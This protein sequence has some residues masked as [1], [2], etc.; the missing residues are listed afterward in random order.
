MGKNKNKKNKP[1]HKPDKK[2]KIE[3]L[4]IMQVSLRFSNPDADR[5]ADINYAFDQ[6]PDFICFGEA[7]EADTT[8]MIRNISNERGYGACT[9]PQGDSQLSVRLKGAPDARIK[10]K[11]GVMA[12]RAI[13]GSFGARYVRWARVNWFDQDIW[14]H[15][16]HWVFIPHVLESHGEL[17][18]VHQDQTTTMCNQVKKHGQGN[19]ISFF[20]GDINVDE[21]ADNASDH[22]NM[23][24]FIFRQK[25]LLTIWDELHVNPPIT[26]AHSTFDIIGSYRPD[27]QV[28]GK[29]YIV[30][31]KQNSDHRFVSAFY[32]I[33]VAKKVTTGGGGGDGGDADEPDD[34][35]GSADVDLFV[36]ANAGNIDWSDYLDNE[37]YPLPT[38]T[39]DSQYGG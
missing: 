19:A 8:A 14:M 12:H 17:T 32:D 37:L 38:A 4:H 1:K 29:R 31:P 20:A 3:Q 22:P 24:N 9:F 7:G 25:G 26:I 23:P 13:P 34:T 5:R 39:G 10:S 27:K 2:K 15:A 28:E 33:D 6:G 16:A 11:G 36:Y 18:K 30:H 21:A 35:D